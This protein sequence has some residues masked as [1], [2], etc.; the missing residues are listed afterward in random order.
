MTQ[1]SSNQ[2]VSSKIQFSPTNPL[3]KACLKKLYLEDNHSLKQTI[4]L[5]KNKKGKIDLQ[6]LKKNLKLDSA[7][8]SKFPKKYKQVVK[9]I[10]QNMEE[11]EISFQ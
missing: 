4:K 2:K 7:P 3:R 6:K 8:K 9:E 10:R 1:A 5:L 11:D